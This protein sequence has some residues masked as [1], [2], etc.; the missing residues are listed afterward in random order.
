MTLNQSLL[1]SLENFAKW[2][3][4][5]EGKAGEIPNFLNYIYSGALEEI[6]PKAVTIFK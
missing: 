4:S 1:T 5:K 3:M 2:R 6:D